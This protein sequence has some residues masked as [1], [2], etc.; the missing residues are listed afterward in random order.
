MGNTATVREDMKARLDNV[1]E[2]YILVMND[3]EG[4]PQICYH[5]DIITLLQAS[6]YLLGAVLSNMEDTTEEERGALRIILDG[7]NEEER[8]A[9]K[10]VLEG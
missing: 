2:D 4:E 1:S 6:K 3:E 8:E 7:W 5:T 9:L 10:V